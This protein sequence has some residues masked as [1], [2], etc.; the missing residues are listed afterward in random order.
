MF[1]PRQLLLS[2]LVPECSEGTLFLT[3]GNENK[4]SPT[5]DLL[6]G[7]LWVLGTVRQRLLPELV[8]AKSTCL[9]CCLTWLQPA[10]LF[11]IYRTCVIIKPLT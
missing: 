6:T 9:T 3:D 2:T 10:S 5:P 4:S 8:F 11:F 1:D 7:A